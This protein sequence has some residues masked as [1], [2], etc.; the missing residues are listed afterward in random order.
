VAR[1]WAT[2]EHMP[3]RRQ[4]YDSSYFKSNLFRGRADSPRNLKRLAEV[5]HYKASGRLLEI[6]CG[7]GEFLALAAG[8]FNVEGVDVAAD[9]LEHVPPSL[10][11]QVRQAD[12]QHTAL[13]AG[14]F[15][16]VVAFNTLEHLPEPQLGVDNIFRALA[17][18][19]VLVGSVPL[20]AGPV[21]TVH[22]AITN[23]F[24]QTHCSTLPPDQWREVFQRGG[25]RD[26]R[27]FGELQMG[28][29]RCW[30]I[31]NATWRYVS[32][33]LMFVGRA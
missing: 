1:G 16:V 33:N 7:T 5:L 32:P 10:R 20:N 8:H 22:T 23:V 29:N 11:S 24:D 4:Q 19:G 17:P 30:Y 26:V 15:D 18:G 31:R 13:P 12:I 27:F 28:P 3:L 21:G 2:P 6:G 25:F 9:A 14:R